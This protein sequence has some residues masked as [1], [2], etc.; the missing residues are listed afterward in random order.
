MQ[1]IESVCPECGK[2]NDFYLS[3]NAEQLADFE[4]EPDNP[5]L[6]HI[7]E[8]FKTRQNQNAVCPECLQ[9]PIECSCG[10]DY[11]IQDSKNWPEIKTV[12]DSYN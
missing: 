8:D 4:N 12:I 6:K 1:K 2:R 7:V 5:N 9:N 3:T 11:D 10:C